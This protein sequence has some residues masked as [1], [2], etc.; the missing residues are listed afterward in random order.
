MA[1][2]IEKG[3]EMISARKE[4]S[5]VPSRKGHAPYTSLTGSQVVPHRYFRPNDLIEGM[6]CSTRVRKMPSTSTT[7]MSPINIRVLLKIFSVRICR[8]D[9]RAL[10]FAL[11]I[12]SGEE[13]ITRSGK[14][15]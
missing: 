12:A 13:L 3:I 5:K 6:D 10:F 4:L 8:K 1:I 9:S 14:S 7:M 2:E 11:E 15:L